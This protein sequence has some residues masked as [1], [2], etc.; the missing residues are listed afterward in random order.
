[1][2]RSKG[3]YICFMTDKLDTIHAF[4]QAKGLNPSEIRM[5]KA[6]IFMYV[7]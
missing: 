6:A 3:F 1:M 4:A 5:P 7:E 2:K